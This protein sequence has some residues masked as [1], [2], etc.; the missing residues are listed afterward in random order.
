VSMDLILIDVTEIPGAQIDDQV[1]L[2]GRQGDKT[3]TAEEIGAAA[4]TISYEITCGISNR[5]PRVYKDENA[6]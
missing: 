5:V 2:L 4:G 3:I 6:E 1:I